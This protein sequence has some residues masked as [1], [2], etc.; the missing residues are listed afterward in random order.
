MNKNRQKGK[1]YV[2]PMVQCHN[3]L[4]T[5]NTTRQHIGIAVVTCN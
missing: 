1:Q 4:R 2:K 5:T 3:T